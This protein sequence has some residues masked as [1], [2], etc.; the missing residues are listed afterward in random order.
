ML[1]RERA[2]FSSPPFVE[3][4]ARLEGW[5]G[6]EPDGDTF[7]EGGLEAWRLEGGEVLRLLVDLFDFVDRCRSLRPESLGLGGSSFGVP[8][9]VGSIT[10]GGGPE[11]GS[12]PFCMLLA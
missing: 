12:W 2:A 10:I 7:A 11:V 6:G 3:T 5:F 9:A 8:G 1:E 4:V